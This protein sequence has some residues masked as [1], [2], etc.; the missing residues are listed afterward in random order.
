MVPLSPPLTAGPWDRHRAPFGP[1]S[2]RRFH[3]RALGVASFDDFKCFLAQNLPAP[4]T[5]AG[6][7]GTISESAL[8]ESIQ[9]EHS[10]AR[11]H[12]YECLFYL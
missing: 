4:K 6:I 9:K 12:P 11:S 8:W 1:Q 7:S 5:K 10:A 2:N 3:S